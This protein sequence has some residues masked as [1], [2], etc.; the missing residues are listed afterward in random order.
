[1]YNSFYSIQDFA[2]YPDI[3]NVLKVYYLL[4]FCTTIINYVNLPLSEI[5][6]GT[7]QIRI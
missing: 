6:T 2:I 5:K 3:E 1:M 7:A 4:P